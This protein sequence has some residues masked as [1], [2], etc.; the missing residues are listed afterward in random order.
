VKRIGAYGYALA[1]IA[2]AGTIG[3]VACRPS[4][5]AAHPNVLIIL[6]D[7]LRADH[8]GAYGY[9]R[10]TSPTFD[11]LAARGTLFTRTYSTTSWTN[12]AVASLF[13]GGRPLVLEPGAREY[14][15][16]AAT[17]LAGAFLSAGYRT[18]AVVGNAFLTSPQGFARGFQDYMLAGPP[19]NGWREVVK[20]PAERLNVMALDWLRRA[21]KT[22]PWLLYVHYM[23]PHW[24]YEPPPDLAQR[25][26]QTAAVK[27]ADVMAPLNKKL[28]EHGADLTPAETNQAIDLYDAAIASFDA[29]LAELLSALEGDGQL[30]NT[31]VCITADHGEE[32]ADHGRFR[33]ARTLYEEVVHIPLLFVGPGVRHEAVDV[34]V[35]NTSI[36]RSLM[37]LAGNTAGAFPGVSL[38][39]VVSPQTMPLLLELAPWV[40]AVH[41]QALVWQDQK[42]IVSAAGERFLFDLKTDPTE[43]QTLAQTRPE[44]TAQLT[45]LL[46]QAMTVTAERAAPSID[47]SAKE[48]MRALGYDF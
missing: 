7:T 25:F 41:H 39:P 19:G 8:L 42:L 37:D 43:K 21:P 45:Q 20:Q 22:T 16:P 44:L 10:P 27:V 18:A 12:P 23:E 17:T 5:P 32:F 11:A 40:E 24:P 15:P 30:S 9:H 34:T 26:W 6:V 35:Q 13:T 47:T 31:I 1:V 29:R 36:G 2:F 28:R 48:R 33:H 3:L 38:F 46:A 14:I 4:G